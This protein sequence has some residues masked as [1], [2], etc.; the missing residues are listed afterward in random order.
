V[1][2][3]RYADVVAFMEAVAASSPWIHL[4]TMGYTLEGRAIP[5]AVVGEVVSAEPDAVRAAGGLRVYLQGT[6]HGGEVPG[7]EALLMLLRDLAR[8]EAPPPWMNDVVLLVVP[9]YNADGNERVSL[10]HRPR[11]HGPLAGMGQRANAQGLDLNR[12]HM[13]LD[14]PEARSF[15]AMLQAWDPHL[16]VDLHTTNGTRHGYHLTYAPPLHPGT[17][18]AI[19]RA[20]DQELLPAVRTAVRERH[21]VEFYDY[22]NAYD[23]P[24]GPGWYT[25]DHRPRFNNNYLGLRNRIAILSEAYAYLT[26]RDRVRA[27][28]WFVDAIL[29]YAAEHA[30]G[31]RDVVE[32]AD[33]SVVGRRLAL[34][35]TWERSDTLVPILLG[36]VEEERH[37]LTGETLLRRRDVTR[38]EPMWEYTTFR[39][40]EME[41]APVA[42]LVPPELTGVVD[43]LRAHGVRLEEADP[44]PAEVQEF[45]LDSVSTAERP[46]QGRR[47]RTLHGRW[48][49]ITAE[50][51]PGTLRLEV[52]QP[53]GRLA[54][55]LL[56]P[57]SDD[58]L[59][60]W[61][62]LDEALEGASVHPVLRV[63]AGADPG[64]P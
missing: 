58:G 28:R 8:S 61:G 57:R 63:P 27:T 18:P 15:A 46:F 1:E 9:L 17:H 54:V 56:E 12:D 43:R 60:T 13:K 22:G 52:D 55:Y 64:S 45:A 10:T 40:T 51:A 25:F 23:G 39:G 53:L 14:S 35:A 29:A 2:T 30:D 50:V 38:P 47:E 48:R 16:S 4:T 42:Y 49:A 37:P 20:V 33:A 7:K 36:E 44:G 24:E 32:A 19:L 62:L 26:F 34:R 6:I 11:Q 21:G 41:T 3:S 5:M 59:A 31:L